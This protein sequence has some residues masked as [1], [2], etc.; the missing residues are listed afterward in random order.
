MHSIEDE[1]TLPRWKKL[2]NII[3]ITKYLSKLIAKPTLTASERRSRWRRLR[4]KFG[5]VR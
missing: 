4:V 2:F 1:R 3:S 5:S